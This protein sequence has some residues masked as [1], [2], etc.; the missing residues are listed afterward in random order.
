[1]D[2]IFWPVSFA[3]KEEE[4]III[5]RKK[6]NWKVR[7]IER[8]RIPAMPV[9]QRRK[10]NAWLNLGDRPYG[11]GITGMAIFISTTCQRK[12]Y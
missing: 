11:V 3:W 7:F 6:R 12:C 1:M 10:T 2:W 4:K 5:K 9:F 8:R